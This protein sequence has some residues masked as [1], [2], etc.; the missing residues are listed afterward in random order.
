MKTVLIRPSN[1]GGSAYLTKFGFLPLPLG[2]LQLASSLLT[3]ED[4]EVRVIDME[5]DEKRTVEDAVKEALS[6]DPDMVGLTIHATA[7]HGTST[8]IAKRVKEGKENTLL[9]AGGHHATFVPYDLL[10]NGFDVVAL[11]EGDQTITEIAAAL[12][13]GERFEKIPGILFNKKEYGKSSIVQNTPRALI[14]NLDTL[15]LPA[16]HLVRKELYTIKLFGEGS[17][18]CLETSRGCPYAC[19]FCSVTPTWGHKWRN[20]SNKRI[21]ME[22]RTREKAWV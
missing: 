22:L 5:A 10:R 18:T 16:L 11:G 4:S 3:L 12:R 6:F 8:E 19:D 13:G 20:K 7:A 9:V 1:P 17:I 14:P 2:L 21:L 15:P